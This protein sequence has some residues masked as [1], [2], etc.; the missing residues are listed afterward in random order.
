MRLNPVDGLL[1]LYMKAL[2]SMD[3]RKSGLEHLR[4]GEAKS[5]LLVS[6]TAIGDTLLS[7]PAI[8]AVRKSYPKAK[9]IAHLNKK[10]MELFE[11]NPNI[12][13]IIPYYGGYRRFFQTVR[14]FRRHSFDLALIFHG[15]EPQATPMCYLSGARFIIKVPNNGK[16]SFLLSNQSLVIPADPMRHAI[17]TRLKVAELA[18]CRV[19]D[20]R[21]ELPIDKK[22]EAS[23]DGFLKEHKIG[24]DEIL[25]GIQ[26]GASTV[27]RMWFKDRYIEL[28]R[29]ILDNY[30][31]IKIVITGSPAEKGLCES[32]GKALGARTV[33][34]AGRV[35]LKETAPLIR[36]LNL[37]ITCDTGPMHIAI[38]WKTPIVGLFAVAEP[39]GTGPYYDKEIHR[40]I[41]KPRVCDP[42]VSKRCEYQKCMEA[43]TVDEVYSVV[44][45]RLDTFLKSRVSK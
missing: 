16:F 21:M 26:P 1:H 2:K 29:R 18:L 37:F 45:D 11:N 32:I 6:S 4:P 10:N 39:Q 44:K 22:D 40:V 24:R 14:E 28:G 27:S 3:K 43:I 25:I 8:R 31:A 19:D 15:N 20:K 42:C 41:K 13:G 36:R 7:T 9:I 30:P 5:I 12:D 23:L 17:E 38:A 35:R 34:A 33:V